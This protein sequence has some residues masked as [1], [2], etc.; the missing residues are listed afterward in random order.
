MPQNSRS[1]GN[2]DDGTE[3]KT[4]STRHT[5][6][7]CKGFAQFWAHVQP[8]GR[9]ADTGPGLCSALVAQ[10]LVGWLVPG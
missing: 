10:G 8:Q 9:G 1:H 7:L 6:R 4:K 3:I 5:P 2:N